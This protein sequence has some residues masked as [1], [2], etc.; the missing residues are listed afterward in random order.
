MYKKSKRCLDILVVV[1]VTVFFFRGG[2][3][4]SRPFDTT[5]AL[6]LVVMFRLAFITESQ[7]QLRGYVKTAELGLPEKC[8]DGI[9]WNKMIFR[10]LYAIIRI[11]KQIDLSKSIQL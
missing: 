9:R 1:E 2:G 6:R 8:T 10:S 5:A 7:D 3:E 4:T 11:Y